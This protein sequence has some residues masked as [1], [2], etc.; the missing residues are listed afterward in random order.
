MYKISSRLSSKIKD[1]N[2]DLE[3][4]ENILDGHNGQIHGV[5][6]LLDLI[7]R[8]LKYRP[9]YTR[10]GLSADNVRRAISSLEFGT[11]TLLNVLRH[12]SAAL[13]SHRVRAERA[14]AVRIRASNDRA[15]ARGVIGLTMLLDEFYYYSDQD[16]NIRIFRE[17]GLLYCSECHNATFTMAD[18]LELHWGQ[19]HGP[20]LLRPM[21]QS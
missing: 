21:E 14:E 11:L 12:G 7:E 2:H 3:E 6:R 16:T 18:I 19:D 10:F 8:H 15:V 5:K 13:L 1:I 17:T 9:N 20:R 4:L